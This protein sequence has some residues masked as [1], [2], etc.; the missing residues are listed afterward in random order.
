M[1]HLLWPI[2]LVVGANTVYN[3]A[4]KSTPPGINSF[5]SLAVSYFVAMVSAIAL[6]FATSGQKNL[7]AEF[8]KMNWT[9]V[10]LGLSLIHI[11]GCHQKQGQADHQIGAKRTRHRRPAFPGQGPVK[12]IAGKRAANGKAA[13]QSLSL[14]HILFPGGISGFLTEAFPKMAHLMKTDGGGDIPDGPV[15]I[16]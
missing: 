5:A 14:I 2:L 8:S 10:A 16:F 11:C 3:I 1:F 9:S 6:F 4:A 7:L 13:G 15:G 12:G